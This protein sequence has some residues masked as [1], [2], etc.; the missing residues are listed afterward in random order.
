MQT[1][2]RLVY[3]PGEHSYR[4][5]FEKPNQRGQKNHGRIQKPLCDMRYLNPGLLKDKIIFARSQNSQGPNGDL[6]QT[7]EDYL[8][9]YA[10]VEEKSGGYS[11]EAG[12][13]NSQS[14]IKVIIR[15]RGANSDYIKVG[16][17]VTWRGRSWVITASPVVDSWR[18]SVA[19][20]AVLM[21]DSSLRTSVDTGV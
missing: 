9:T 13:V 12:K 8:E 11:V 16:D 20:E 6:I 17:R 14:R 18:T 7:F 3:P 1:S 2:D 5:E 19:M 15:Y 21:V 4:N 10:A